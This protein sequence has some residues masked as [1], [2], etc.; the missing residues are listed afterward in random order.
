MAGGRFATDLA[1]CAP[2]DKPGGVRRSELDCQ[3]YT[4]G[5]PPLKNRKSLQRC[6]MRTTP[7]WTGCPERPTFMIG[8]F[9][10]S[11]SR[12]RDWQS[13]GS[14]ASGSTRVLLRE[15]GTENRAERIA[16]RLVRLVPDPTD[17]NGVIGQVGTA[18]AAMKRLDNALTLSK[19]DGDLLAQFVDEWCDLEIPP[20]IR[21]IGVSTSKLT[22]YA[23]SGLRSILMAVQIPEPTVAKLYN[24]LSRLN[25]SKIPAFEPCRS[26]RQD[27]TQ[28]S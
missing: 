15:P 4:T 20:T 5:L 24:K 10:S 8:H 2:E 7:V 18:L 13:S 16:F 19:E 21:G 11:P 3:A 14:V 9:S 12:V 27:L 28:S 25:E 22:R 6:G 1:P 17:L 23:V 26:S